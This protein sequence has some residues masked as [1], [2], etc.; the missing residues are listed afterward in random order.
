MRHHRFKTNAQLWA[1]IERGNAKFQAAS[2]AEKRVRL[3]KDVL[4]LLDAGYLQASHGTYGVLS[5]EQARP[6]DR[7][8][9]SSTSIRDLLERQRT[10]CKVC[11]LGALLLTKLLKKNIHVHYSIRMEDELDGLYD[12]FTEEWTDEIERCFE[13]WNYTGSD[14]PRGSKRRRIYAQR[15]KAIEALKTL[16]QRAPE[17]R[18]SEARLRV[19]METIIDSPKGNAFDLKRLQQNAEARAAGDVVRWLGQRQETPK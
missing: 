1:H 6:G 5:E 13:L 11:A 7:P 15:G 16:E 4:A 17:Q 10:T 18:A 3:A 9:T 8:A 12:V 14:A 2:E 19:I